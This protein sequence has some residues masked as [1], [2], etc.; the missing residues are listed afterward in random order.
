MEDVYAQLL[1]EAKEQ[2]EVQETSGWKLAELTF[3]AVNELLDAGN[4]KEQ[5]LL[6]WAEDLDRQQFSLTSARRYYAIWE[7]YGEDRLTSEVDDSRE[8][9][10]AE[11]Y[12]SVKGGAGV[13]QRVQRGQSL[14]SAARTP[15]I[16]SEQQAAKHSAAL[17]AAKINSEEDEKASTDLAKRID[18]ATTAIEY[19]LAWLTVHEGLTTEQLE[20]FEAFGMD[21]EKYIARIRE[22]VPVG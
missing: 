8:L 13:R 12:A 3:E 7:K 10:F 22:M 11:H 20:E 5:S 17:A 2:I 15:E 16:I 4:N 1:A 9:S 21:L 19:V 14:I 18:E 6:K